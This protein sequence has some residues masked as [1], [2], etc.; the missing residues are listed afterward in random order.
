MGLSVAVPLLDRLVKAIAQAFHGAELAP[1]TIGG[2]P[3]P[4]IVSS[5]KPEDLPSET[6]A[7]VEIYRD[8]NVR[9]SAITNDHYHY[10]PGSE[11]AQLARSYSFR[12][13]A[14]GRVFVYTGDTGPS[15]NLEKQAG[16]TVMTGFLPFCPVVRHEKTC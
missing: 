6:P 10:A 13:E 3:M 14:G 15:R 16:K 11:S 1:I 5:V 8:A 2:P 7:P 9:V 12:I 4:T